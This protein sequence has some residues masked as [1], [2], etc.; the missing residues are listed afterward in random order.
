M[1]VNWK[2]MIWVGFCEWREEYINP[3][4]F[5]ISL[6]CRQNMCDVLV[7]LAHEMVHVSQFTS[8]KLKHRIKPYYKFIWDGVEIFPD[9]YKYEELPWEKEAYSLELPLYN[10]FIDSL[11]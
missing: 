9:E 11:E 5:I 1:T 4:D 2:L 3:R 7:S 6:N 10:Q 8:N